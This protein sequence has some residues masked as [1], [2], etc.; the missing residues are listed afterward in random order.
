[1]KCIDEIKLSA[2]IDGELSD[3]EMAEIAEH[4]NTCSVCA[5]KV[6]EYEELSE[7]TFQ[8]FKNIEN[9]FELPELLNDI[10]ER[11]KNTDEITPEHTVYNNKIIDFPKNEKN[12]EENIFK[13]ESVFEK[14]Y[15]FA[16]AIISIAAII[17]IS[18]I[19]F[20][21]NP[22]NNVTANKSDK[23]TVDS[24]EYSKFKAMIYK[25]KEKNK[26]VI[27]LFDDNSDEDNGD[28]DSI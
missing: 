16:P 19:L 1:M 14:I 23:V 28:D 2:Y 20:S 6:K 11:L 8:Y 7:N 17:M 9:S 18:F 24:L 15:K 3:K 5:D 25:T 22:K 26:T 12:N 4:L 21:E 13:E 27:W 10:K